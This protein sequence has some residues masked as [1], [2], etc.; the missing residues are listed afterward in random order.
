MGNGGVMGADLDST[1]RTEALE[2]ERARLKAELL[3]SERTRNELSAKLERTEAEASTARRQLAAVLE[4]VTD[5]FVALDHDWRCTYVNGLAGELLGKKPSELIGRS[6][7]AE[8]PEGAAQPFRVAYQRATAEQR[9]ARIEEYFPAWDRWFRGVIHPSPDGPLV[10]F[11]DVTEQKRTEQALRRSEVKHRML[12]ETAGDAIFLVSNGRFVDCNARTLELFGCS[13]EEIIGASPDRFSPPVQADGRSSREKSLDK[14]A[15]ALA[16]VPQIFEWVH[17]QADRRPFHAEVSLN[18]LELG[19]EVLLQAIVRDISERKRM[20][21]AL[22]ASEREYRELVLA[23]NSI[24]LRWGADG[25]VLF[26]NDFGLRFFGYTA[27]QIVGRHVVGTIVPENEST[28][29]D[30]GPLMEHICAN[31]KDFERN[32]NENRRSN[33][34]RVWVDWANKV[35]LDEEG[36]FK[37]ILSIGS[38]ITERREA[39]RRVRELNDALQRHT[40]TLEESIRARTAQLAAKNQELKDF[41]YTVSHDLKAPLRGIAGYASELVRK[42][43]ACLN[44]RARF[45]LAQIQNA[46]SQLDHLIED[47]L[48]YSRLESETP[49]PTDIDLGALVEALLQDRALLLSEQ[50]VEVTVDV[51]APTLVHAWERGLAQVLGNLIDNAIKYS[52]SASP[53]R[54]RIASRALAEAWQIAVEDNGIGFDMKYHDRIFGLFNRLVRGEDYE[55]TGAGLAIVKKVIDKQGGRI[56]AESSPGQGATF[57]VELPKPPGAYGHPGIEEETAP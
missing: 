7:S 21:A 25:R 23:A 17:C 37:E 42:H 54:L 18:R 39:E 6:L 31:P 4:Q 28:G 12:F 15:Q 30:L 40:E 35:V 55:G 51:P 47:L 36:Q 24:I 5:A 45:C 3:R 10:Y 14:M 38:D 44:D 33:G 26:L 19:G 49:S 22:R 29:R 1:G 57:F 32:I 9:P 46:A 8:L 52:R 27:E 16:G 2:Q 50:Q 20:E 11:H 48:H 41:T 56:W 43:Q 34:E 53:P 13:R